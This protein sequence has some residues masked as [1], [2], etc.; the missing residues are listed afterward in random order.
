MNATTTS[1]VAKKTSQAKILSNKDFSVVFAPTIHQVK[2]E[3]VD[4]AGPASFFLSDR[5]LA[6]L[7]ANPPAG[8]QF[9]YLLFYKKEIPVGIAVMQTLPFKADKSLNEPDK[10]DGTDACFFRAFGRYLKGLV[11]SKVEFTTLICGNMLIT[12]EHGFYFNDQLVS[13]TQSLDLLEEGLEYAQERLAEREI[14]TDVT[15]IKDF[16]ENT[17][18]T[19]RHLN[20]EG[21][22]EFC[23]Q[24]NMILEVRDDWKSFDDYLAA[25]TSKYRTRAK[26]AYK[27]LDPIYSRV[28][29]SN[30]IES[31]K[32]EIYDLYL[33]VT[34]NAGFNVVS[35]NENYLQGLKDHLGDDFQLR[36]YFFE[37]ELVAFYT[38]IKNHSEL[39]AHFVGYNPTYNAEHQVYLSMLY[40]MIRDGIEAGYKTIN[41]ART[42][43]EI[44]SSVGAEPHEM[45]CY[46]RHRHQF[47]NKFLKPLMEYLSPE[48]DWTP[49]S[50]FKD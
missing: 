7:E 24:P 16:F 13:E 4:V 31:Y 39:E 35:L 46:I 2:E 50:P 37:N 17:R 48:L 45:F 5:Y 40:D 30:E 23:A 18:E 12:G 15:F 38:T 3:W 41:F 29:D 1:G 25:M 8:M 33:N 42:A 36:G 20:N 22:Y 49:R 27:K 9:A 44:K 26:R 47:A 14:K 21:Y 28:L 34:E 43:L 6:S 32:K 19:T 10:R 11:A